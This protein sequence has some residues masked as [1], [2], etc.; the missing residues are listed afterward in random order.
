[1]RVALDSNCVSYV[2]AAFSE[3]AEPAGDLAAE[4]KALFRSYFYLVNCF[5]VT[6]EVR[7]ECA[8]I[9]GVE[10]KLLH[11]QFFSS[12]FP[13]ANPNDPERVFSLTNAFATRHTKLRDCRILAEANAAQLDAL[14]SFDRKFVSK[15][16]AIASPV[17][18]MRP[19]EFWQKYKPPP[20]ARPLNRPDASN[21]LAAQ[22]WWRI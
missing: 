15:L 19:S 2:V 8:E 3:I 16:T 5:W 17:Q 9:P 18:L 22:V 13:T 21:P 14:L 12:L 4:K 10:Q 1:V 11:E 20:G 7:K 6:P